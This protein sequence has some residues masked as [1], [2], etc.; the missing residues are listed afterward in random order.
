M[1]N[2]WFAVFKVKVKMGAHIV[3]MIV[4]TIFS[5]MLIILQPNSF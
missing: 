2:D 1:Q 5:E 4:S 3:K